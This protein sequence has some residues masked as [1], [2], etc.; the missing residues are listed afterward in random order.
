MF[1]SKE[2]TKI[3]SNVIDSIPHMSY[4]D[5]ER[6]K[7]ILRSTYVKSKIIDFANSKG[8]N[9]FT[10]AE[11][12][13]AIFDDTAGLSEAAYVGGIATRLD[14]IEKRKVKV[15]TTVEIEAEGIKFMLPVTAEKNI[16]R[17]RQ[18][19]KNKKRG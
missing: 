18:P 14:S 6:I 12:A 3:A 17:L 15:A 9:W 1:T 11:C 19:K 7:Q 16:W 5:Q 8:E 4:R 2:L 10:S 13:K